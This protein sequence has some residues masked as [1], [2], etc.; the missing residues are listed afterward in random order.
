MTASTR[1]ATG[2]TAGPRRMTPH[3]IEKSRDQRVMFAE[4]MYALS[5]SA[6]R[7][8]AWNVSTVGVLRPGSCAI[9]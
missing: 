3:S 7:I 2:F 8:F 4:P 9:A 5:S 1:V 6:R